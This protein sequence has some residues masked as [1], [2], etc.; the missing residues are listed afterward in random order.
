MVHI[1]PLDRAKTIT[2]QGAPAGDLMINSLYG[3]G[4]W[5]DSRKFPDGVY[6]NLYGTNLLAGYNPLPADAHVVIETA[7]DDKTIRRAYFA[8]AAGTRLPNQ[9]GISSNRFR[10][11]KLRKKIK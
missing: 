1:L 10:T 4:F 2:L 11:L 8:D 7:D 6:R 3:N 9:N 5:Y